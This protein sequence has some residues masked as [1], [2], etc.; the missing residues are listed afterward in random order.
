[1]KEWMVIVAVAIAVFSAGWWL[2]RALATP[3]DTKDSSRTSGNTMTAIRD[4]RRA[5]M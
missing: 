5:D 4:F 3:T 1:M 2:V